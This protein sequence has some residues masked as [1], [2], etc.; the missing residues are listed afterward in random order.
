MRV[1]SVNF[2]SV[3]GDIAGNVARAA[4]VI[5]A[6]MP[7]DLVLLPELFTAGYAATDLTP[8]AEDAGGL[9][10]ATFQALVEEL[11]IVLGWGFAQRADV[12]G[13]VYNAWALVEPGRAPQI[14]RKTHLHPYHPGHAFDEPAFLVPGG[15]LGLV[16]TRLGRFGVMICFDGCFVEVPRCLVLSGAQAILW[17]TR[18]GGYLAGAGLP[19]VRAIDNVVSILMAEGA[20]SGAH[21]LPCHAQLCDHTGAILAEYQGPDGAC[22]LADIDLNAAQATRATPISATGQY[23]VRRPELYGAITK[24]ISSTHHP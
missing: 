19:R 24:S 21:P 17:P 10:F 20:Q 8:W 18:S 14:V 6:N 4:D 23:C 15:A 7:A 2:N 12:P 22:L 9:T 13:K 3:C 16:D 11:D 1:L 5:R